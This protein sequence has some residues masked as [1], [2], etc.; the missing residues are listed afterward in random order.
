M[1][2][3]ETQ[4]ASYRT[5]VRHHWRSLLIVATGTFSFVLGS[6]TIQSWGQ[7]L[8]HEG[9]LLSTTTVATLF[10]FV[11]LADLLGRLGVAWLADKIGRR[12][13]LLMCGVLGAS[14]ALLVAWSASLGADGSWIVFFGGIVIAMAFGD[15]AFGI[16]NTFGAEQFPNEVRATGLGLGYGIG[17]SAKIIGPMLMGL[18]IGGSAVRPTVTLNAV[19]PAFNVFAI[20]LLAGGVIYMFA[21]ETNGK[22]LDAR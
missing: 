4:S 12:P 17:A 3:N 16:L 7:T 8:L 6:A 21:E 1:S 9:Y 11:S 5:V 15:G 2:S 19:V 13:T 14:G 18:L 20:L 10:M 22:S